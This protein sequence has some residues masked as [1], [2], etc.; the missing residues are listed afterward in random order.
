MDRVNN[1]FAFLPMRS[2]NDL[3]GDAEALRERL[4][5]DSYLLFR[6]VLDPE[7]VK[8][9]RGMI[10]WMLSTRGWIV[11][12]NV[13]GAGRCLI[14]PL[15]ENDEEY[16]AG[17][18]RV[19]KLEAFHSLAHDPA[20]VE[21]MQQVVGPTAFPHPLKIARLAFPGNYEAST[22]PHQDFPN[23]QGTPAL[24]AAW[25]PVM[26]LPPELGGLAVLRGSHRW[27]VMPLSRHFGAGNRCATIP[28]EV[29]EACR[30]VTTDFELGDIL[31]FPSTTVHAA[32]HNASEF[33]LR[34]SVDF[35]YQQE[36]EALTAGCLEPHFGQLSWDEIY[37]G[38]KSTDLQYYW[39]DLDYE[40]VPF[41]EFPIVD[42]ELGSDFTAQEMRE[43]Y[44][45]QERL[46][47]RT[48][49]RLAALESEAAVPPTPDDTT[50]TVPS[51]Q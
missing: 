47:A 31:L 8:H 28:E 18:E 26:D 15:R 50:G 43:I 40:V 13:P 22:P 14:A 7:R 12:P 27:G 42:H 44:K 6:R 34:L 4:D 21:I 48:A 3:L 23:N 20:L 9:L 32:L 19:Q 36:G 10:Q 37:R 29:S 49:R 35:R 45:Y 17:Y 30:W 2:S 1:R 5:A 24:T 41:E 51:A 25:I 38:W 46:D 16:Q 39:K 11:K 33:Q